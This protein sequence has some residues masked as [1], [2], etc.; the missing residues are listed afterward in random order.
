MLCPICISPI[1]SPLTLHCNHTFCHHCI[2]M[3]Y[4]CC[5][6]KYIYPQTPF[7]PCPICRKDGYNSDWDVVINDYYL[8][9]NC[10]YE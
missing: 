5:N 10:I 9:T 8:K 7:N 6:S 4:C 2:Y 3:W 1:S